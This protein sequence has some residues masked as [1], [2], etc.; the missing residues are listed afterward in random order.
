LGNNH[1]IKILRKVKMDE[2][3]KNL[4]SWKEGKNEKK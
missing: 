1:T 4:Y 2:L 3:I